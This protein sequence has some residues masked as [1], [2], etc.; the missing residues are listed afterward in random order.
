MAELIQN[1]YQ[2]TFDGVGG[3]ELQISV[4]NGG[5]TGE[6]EIEDYICEI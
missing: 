5:V 4:D 1:Q 3:D 2:I 6:S